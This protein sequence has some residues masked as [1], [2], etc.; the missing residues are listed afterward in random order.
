MFSCE[1]SLFSW[2]ANLSAKRTGGGGRAHRD[3]SYGTLTY[4]GVGHDVALLVR[5]ELLD[6]V[7]GGVI[8]K[9]LG[10]V[11]APICS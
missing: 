3:L 10:L 4:A 1:S 8:V 9:A 7:D 11:Y 5:F 6:S 2:G